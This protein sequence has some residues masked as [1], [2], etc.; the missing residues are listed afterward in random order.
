M[1]YGGKSRLPFV[2]I[3]SDYP[4]SASSN[5]KPVWKYN[6]R[7]KVLRIQGLTSFEKHC[8][9][10]CD[11]GH[12]INSRQS[13]QD[14][15]NCWDT[16]SYTPSNKKRWNQLLLQQQNLKK[17]NSIKQVWYASSNSKIKDLLLKWHSFCWMWYSRVLSWPLAEATVMIYNLCWQFQT[18]G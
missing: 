13:N 3:I 18:Q 17:S 6:Y 2:L 12:G 5:P 16:C 8:W 9:F 10:P 1:E 4:A 7:D 14:I 11:P 15:P